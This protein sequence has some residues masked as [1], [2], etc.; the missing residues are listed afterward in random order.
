MFLI[1]CLNR[2]QY[3]THWFVIGWILLLL[4]ME[5]IR[6]FMQFHSSAI[7]PKFNKDNTWGSTRTFILLLHNLGCNSSDP[8]YLNVHSFL[9]EWKV[10]LLSLKTE[11]KRVKKSLSIIIATL[12]ANVFA[13][14]C[15]ANILFRFEPIFPLPQKDS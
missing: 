8:A 7:C 1:K 2:S 6:T 3:Q 5:R 10:T 15:G 11:A 13:F 4:F 12:Y 9:A 14:L